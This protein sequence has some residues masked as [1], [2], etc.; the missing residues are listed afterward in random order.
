M[1]TPQ[2]FVDGALGLLAY[3]A[4]FELV[5]RVT[6]LLID[7]FA[8]E[9]RRWVEYVDGRAQGN[10]HWMPYNDARLVSEY[11]GGIAGGKYTPEQHSDFVRDMHLNVQRVANRVREILSASEARAEAEN[12][13]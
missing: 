7:R 6:C 13:R 2:E 12:G 11:Y 4:Q 8:N 9:V 3:K 10:R 5:D 1:R